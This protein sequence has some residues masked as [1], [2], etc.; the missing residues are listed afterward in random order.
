MDFTSDRSAG[1][2]IGLSDLALLADVRLRDGLR[3]R[4]AQGLAVPDC[5]NSPG[6][7]RRPPFE[8]GTGDLCVL[9]PG[10]RQVPRR[11]RAARPGAAYRHDPWGGLQN[12][13]CQRRRADR[14]YVDAFLANFSP[15]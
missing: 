9:T 8:S 1:C 10:R 5:S 6:S 12:L 2:R 14:D 13:G 4:W 11:F 15:L 3:E 7:D